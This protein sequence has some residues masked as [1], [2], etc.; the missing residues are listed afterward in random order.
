ME[1]G[2][3]E[4]MTPEEYATQWLTT[5]LRDDETETESLAKLIAV[6]IAAERE[7]CALIAE[8]CC[9]A[10]ISSWPDWCCDW[11]PCQSGIADEIRAGQAV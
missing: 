1:E 7:K 11:Y 4:T 2:K 6:A 8:K 5:A 10:G 9:N 3:G